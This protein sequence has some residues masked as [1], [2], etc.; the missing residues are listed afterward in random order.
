MLSS[1]AYGNGEMKK[2]KRN[3][4]FGWIAMGGSMIVSETNRDSLAREPMSEVPY[5]IGRVQRRH[6]CNYVCRCM[7]P[8]MDEDLNLSVAAS[9]LGVYICTIC[10]ALI[11]L[12][13]VGCSFLRNLLLMVILRRIQSPNTSMQCMICSCIIGYSISGLL[14]Q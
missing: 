14:A 12:V 9:F 1:I 7:L 10:A 5:C 3:H 11:S 13:D 2:L 8:V 4:S 6:R